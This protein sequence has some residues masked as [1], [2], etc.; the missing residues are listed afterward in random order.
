MGVR[1]HDTV[2]S[3]LCLYQHSYHFSWVS[4]ALQKFHRPGR[5]RFDNTGVLLSWFLCFILPIFYLT[6]YPWSNILF[7]Y[8][9]KSCFISSRFPIWLFLNSPSCHFLCFNFFKNVF[10]SCLPLKRQMFVG[11]RELKSL[12]RWPGKI[13]LVSRSMGSVTPEQK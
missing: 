3:Y 7:S 6:I 12:P 2:C 8:R 4:L 5:N 10:P 11:N 13:L 9:H 1:K